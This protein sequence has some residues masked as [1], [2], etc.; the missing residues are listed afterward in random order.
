[1]SG[2]SLGTTRH[3]YLCTYDVAEDK[4]RNRLFELLKDHG[5][6]VQYSVFLCE[7][8]SRERVGL[9]ARCG[10]IIHHQEDQLLVIKL[11]PAGLDWTQ[12]LDSVGKIWT[13]M[14]RCN[15]V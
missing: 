6:H 11:G 12:C 7:L 1:M 5:E 9:L 14:I 13:P 10:E 4:R 15:I 3:S 8:T 2:R